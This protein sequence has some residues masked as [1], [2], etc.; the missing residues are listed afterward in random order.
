MKLI[1][2][3]LAPLVFF[4]GIGIFISA[5]GNKALVYS[6]K[7]KTGAEISDATMSLG[8]HKMS[9]GVLIMDATAGYSGGTKGP[10]EG[11]VTIT[12]RDKE[13]KEQKGT[14]TV[15]QKEMTDPRIVV[16]VINP[17]KRIT[18]EWFFD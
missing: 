1:F 17:D 3:F 12:W 9:H 18:K 8:E 14:T 10:R 13:E 2:P 16:F 6:L 11:L 4:I 15:T 7:N 5:C